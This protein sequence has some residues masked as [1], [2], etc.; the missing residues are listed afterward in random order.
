MPMSV[1]INWSKVKTY[2]VSILIPV[3]SGTVVGLII[4]GFMDYNALE[5]PVLAPPPIIFPIAWSILYVL[6]GVSFGMLKSK[7]LA[8]PRVTAV[9]YAQLAVNL[10]WPI[11]FFVLKWRLFAFIWI[12]ILAILVIVTA[13][14]FY[15]KYD[16]AGLLLLPY[17]AWTVFASYLNLF[18]YILNG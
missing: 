2:A 16:T 6:M 7:N 14:R 4:S 8:D 3:V 11:F 13:V 1:S 18:I 10:L 15:R 12:V 9:Y 5:K 17:A